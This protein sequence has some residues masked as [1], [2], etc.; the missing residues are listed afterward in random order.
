MEKIQNEYNG[1]AYFKDREHAEAHMRK[2]AP[3][4]GRVVEY[5]R[6]YV[7]QIILDSPY[8]NKSGE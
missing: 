6:G 2:Y 7:V 4:D 5:E 8:I 1:V 3:E